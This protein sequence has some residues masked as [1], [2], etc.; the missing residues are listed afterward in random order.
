MTPTPQCAVHA[1]RAATA[2]C[3][4]CGAF[5]C[6]VCNPDGQTQCPSCQQ[7]TGQRGAM[8]TPTP[9]ERRG[10]LGLVQAVWQTWRMTILEPASFLNQLDPNGPAMDAFLYGWLISAASGLLQIPFLILNLSQSQAQMK[11]ITGSMKEV[12]PLLQSFFDTAFGNPLVL[13]VG[14]GVS[15]LVLF[16]LSTI[17]AAALT[18]LGV[19]MVG[20]TQNPFSTTLRAICYSLAPNVFAGIPVVGG[21]VGI[22]TVV[23][24]VWA[25]RESHRLTTGRAMVAVLWPLFIFCCC[26]ALGLSVFGVGLARALLK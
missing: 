21:L 9:W 17:I 20:G 16:P 10:E 18:H 15:T 14:I 1:D 4:R 8:P 13:A 22:Y 12:P 19:R 26:G 2:V 7:V 24:E 6:T 3:P 25:I 5:T 11:A 23:L